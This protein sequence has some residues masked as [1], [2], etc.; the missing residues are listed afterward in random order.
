MGGLYTEVLGLDPERLWVTVHETDDEAEAI[1][2][3]AVGAAPERIQRLGEDNF[4]RM[5]DTGPCGPSSEI[6]WDLGPTTAPSGGAKGRRRGPVRRDLEPR[7]HA[8]RRAAGRRARPAAEAE[9]RHGRG[10]RAQP[11]VLQGVD[12]VWDIDV[13]RPLIETAERLTGVEYQGFPGG[14]ADVSLR[15]LAEHARTMTFLV[16]DGVVPSNE[17]RGYV[18]RRII[19]ARCATRTASGA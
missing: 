8:V 18:L 12:S 14:D 3:D 19:R 7:V 10:P 17:E 15:I 11:R 6:F 1:W 9:R 2:R 13:F 16:T 4:W 5:A